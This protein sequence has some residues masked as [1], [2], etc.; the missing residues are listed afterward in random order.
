[1]KSGKVTPVIDRRYGLRET[2]EAMR[3][4]E[5]GHAHGKVVITM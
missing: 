3:Y 1:M 5:Q 4:V 2:P